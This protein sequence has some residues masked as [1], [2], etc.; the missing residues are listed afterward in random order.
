VSTI[1]VI[2]F[3]S[4]KPWQYNFHYLSLA[5][6]LLLAKWLRVWLGPTKVE[7]FNGS[8]QLVSSWLYQ[9]AILSNTPSNLVGSW[10]YPRVYKTFNAHQEKMLK[11]HCPEHQWWRKKLC[12]I[13]TRCLCYVLYSFVTEV[14][15]I[16]VTVFVIGRHL[17]LAKPL[18]V[19]P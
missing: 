15:A 2:Y 7:H 9:Q 11:L 12:N 3:L 4:L 18:W 6:Y 8:T 19:W 14:L 17:N 1:Y 16:L 5:V 10:L 13:D